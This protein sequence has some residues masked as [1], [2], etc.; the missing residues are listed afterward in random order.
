MAQLGVRITGSWFAQQLADETP[1][2]NTK[3]ISYQNILHLAL[4][5]IRSKSSH[6]QSDLPTLVQP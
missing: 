5:D 2:Q 1:P 4:T 3:P 6:A